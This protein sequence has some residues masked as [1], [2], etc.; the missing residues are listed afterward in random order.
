MI[1]S[2][3]ASVAAEDFRE[4]V[5]HLHSESPHA[6]L[7]FIDQIDRAIR[8]LESHPKMGR[9]VPELRRQNITRYRELIVPPWRVFYRIEPQTIYVVSLIDG[10]RNVEEI[11]LERLLRQP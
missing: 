7:E 10:R 4:I 3:W 6:A 2:V 1:R 8:R 9:I 5:E 11:L